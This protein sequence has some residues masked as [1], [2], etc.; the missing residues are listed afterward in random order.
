MYYSCEKSAT[1]FLYMAYMRVRLMYPMS[2]PS[3]SVTGSMAAS[4]LSKV[5]ITSSMGSLNPST[6]GDFDIICATVKCW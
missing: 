2:R 1:I 5:L 4:V 3:V 6:P